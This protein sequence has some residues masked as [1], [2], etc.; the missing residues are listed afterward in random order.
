MASRSHEE[1]LLPLV[2][3]LL[4]E[5]RVQK[6]EV[7]AI[8]ATQ[9]PGLLGSLIVG[10][11]FAKGLSWAWS[12][13]LLS[14]NH[15]EAHVM[16]LF[17]ASP[18]PNYPF[19]CLLVSGG[20]TLLLRAEAPLQA[21][22]LGQSMDDAVGEAFDKVAKMLGL[23]YPGGPEIDKLSAQGDPSAFS[24]PQPN[25][26]ELNYSFSG[27]K[28]AF[29]YFLRKKTA[30]EPDFVSR[31][32]ADLCASIQEALLQHLL[33]KLDKAMVREKLDQIGIVGGVASNRRLR[34]L[35]QR[36]GWK[37]F[38]PALEYCTDNAAMVALVG[39]HKYQKQDFCSLEAS[40]FAR[41]PW[42]SAS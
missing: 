38:S 6:E 24:F 12:K 16:S 36:K 20:H 30:Q 15:L 8:A 26:P 27:L 25:M 42:V 32:L 10:F 34:E 28:T 14:V 40:P 41:Q 29:L 5:E 11:T 18:Q 9:G 3:R 37:T 35:V 19:V 33:A 31:H 4:K 13:P 7:S 22:L 21:R 2:E 39:H 17:L 1:R 23:P